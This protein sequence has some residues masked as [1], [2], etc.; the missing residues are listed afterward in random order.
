[1]E[2]RMRLGSIV[3]MHLPIVRMYSNVIN[4]R[5]CKFIYGFKTI[6]I[7]FTKVL[8]EFTIPNGT[9]VNLYKELCVTTAVFHWSDSYTGHV[10]YALLQSK[11]DITFDCPTLFKTS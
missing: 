1:M 2:S 9:L 5:L 3:Q 4:I 6:L 11:I 8:P 7:A 10:Q